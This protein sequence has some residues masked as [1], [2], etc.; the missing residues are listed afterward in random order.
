MLIK[1]K[2]IERISGPVSFALLKPKKFIFDELKKEGVHLPIFMLF[3]DE[4]FSTEKQCEK[5]TC[6]GSSSYKG[7]CMPIYSNEFLRLIDS[8]ATTEYPIDFGIEGFNLIEDKKTFKQYGEL[9]G[10]LFKQHK[11]KD[12]MEKIRENITICYQR[13]LRG[14]ELYEKYCPT[15]NIRWH[16]MDAR[17]AYGSKYNLESLLTMDGIQ[18]LDEQIFNTIYNNKKQLKKDIDKIKANFNSEDLWKSILRLKIQ[19]IDNPKEAIES[20]F[21]MG[22]NLKNSLVLKQINKLSNSLKDLD[23]WKKAIS[24]YFIY[25]LKE[26]KDHYYNIFIRYL[27][28]PLKEIAEGRIYYYNLLINDD[29]DGL[30]ELISQNSRT[31]FKLAKIGSD[32]NES[33][34]SF[35]LDIYYILRSFKIPKGDKNPFLSILYSGHFHTRN[36]K[37][38]LTN[39]I[40]Y[41]EIVEEVENKTT[42]IDPEMRCTYIPNINFN[43]LALEYGVNIDK[44]EINPS[45]K[46][47]IK[48]SSRR[49]SKRK[50]SRKRGSKKSK[51]RTSRKRRSP[52]PRKTSVR[53]APARRSP[54]RRRK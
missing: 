35:F 39:I 45:F 13:E 11:S 50:T 36:I 19:F 43:K 1:D 2:K 28:D 16:Y 4:H 18:T 54:A 29:I 31:A 20:Y 42:D 25:V 51:R 10:E 46:Q 3:G 12:I 32:L 38:F 53:R 21:Y 33:E 30:F 17:Q 37:Y 8:M 44:Y 52:A 27:D 15:K 23:F 49:T 48:V 7:C 47:N 9:A 41:Y 34:G 24:D 14:T 40:K 6:D 5:C 22:E 26:E